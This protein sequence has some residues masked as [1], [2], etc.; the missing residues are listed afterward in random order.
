MGV[1]RGLYAEGLKDFEVLG[2]IGKMVFTT[3]HVSDFHFDIVDHIDEVE[4]WFAIGAEENK[5]TIL[6]AFDAT[7]H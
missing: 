1:F 4:D 5:V 6:G 3:D 2:S 7:T